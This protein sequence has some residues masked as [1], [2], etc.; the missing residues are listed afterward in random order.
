M[1]R[2]RELLKYGS[3]AYCDAERGLNS[4]WGLS[5]E[6]W[7]AMKD[8]HDAGH[9]RKEEVNENE[10]KECK[11]K[12]YPLRENP[13]QY[14]PDSSTPSIPEKLDFKWPI[15]EQNYGVA[16]KTLEEKQNEIIDFITK[17][18]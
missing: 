8:D 9:P 12:L 18:R 1:T 3:C 2:T 10:V 4:T 13:C 11:H 7:A 17:K 14:C 5:P 6:G 16:I 15:I